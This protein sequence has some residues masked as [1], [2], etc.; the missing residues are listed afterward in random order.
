MGLNTDLTKFTLS[1]KELVTADNLEVMNRGGVKKRWGVTP[2]NSSSYSATVHQIIEWR[3]EDGTLDILA[4]IGSDLYKVSQSDGSLTQLQAVNADRIP[5]YFLNGNLY[6]IDPGTEYYVYNGSSV[7]AVTPNGDSSNDLSPIKKCTM[8]YYHTK[9]HRIFFAGNPDAKSAIYYSEPDDPTYVKGTS[10]L[11]PTRAEGNVLGI[12]VLMD[13]FVVG[14]NHGMWIWRGVTPGTDAVW[15][16]LPTN[17]GP[18][19]PEAFALTTAALGMVSN[20]GIFAVLPSIIGV[21]MENQAGDQYIKNIAKDRVSNLMKDCT[22]PDKIRTVYHNKSSRFL[23]AYCDDGTGQNNKVLSFDF[24]TQGFSLYKGLSINDFCQTTDGKLYAAMDNYIVEFDEDSVEDLDSSGT[25]TVID[26]KMKTPPYSLGNPFLRKKV[27]KIIVAYKNFGLI[28][29]IKMSLYVDGEKVDE[30]TLSGDDS[31][32][33]IITHRQK[34]YYAGQKFSLEFE[35]NQYTP[36]EIY[37]FGLLYT[38]AD[39][40]GSKVNFVE[41]GGVSVS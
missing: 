11:Y 30:F 16:K 34:T 28:I 36:V 24:D 32:T 37:G 7:S 29:D 25:T 3:R 14:Y 17:H 39:T 8:A 19:N 20:E 5:Y 26:F 12:Q 33:E 13:A 21:N 31:G 15:E 22:N 23:I 41:G 35:N 6:F 10:V 9:S 38:P 1:P 40:G 2:L 18:I 27:H 4:L